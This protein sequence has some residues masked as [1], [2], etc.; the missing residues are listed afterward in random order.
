MPGVSW[1]TSGVPVGVSRRSTCVVSA[2]AAGTQGVQSTCGVRDGVW[3]TLASHK[4]LVAGQHWC[5][6]GRSVTLVA[7]HSLPHEAPACP[8]RLAGRWCHPL[9]GFTHAIELLDTIPGVDQRGA[10]V[11]VAEIGIDMARFETAP[12]LAAWAGVAPGNDESA[13]KQRSGKTRK[14]NRSLRAVLTQ[15]AHAAVR[16]KGTNLSA[17]YR[18]LAARRG[19]QRAIIAVAHSIM[20]S[21]F[22]MLSRNEP[23]R[24][25]GANYFDERRRHYT[26]DR[27]A[28]R[29]E[30]LGYHVSLELATTLAA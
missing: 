28:R 9:R 25:L 20:R 29:I 12:R 2:G 3:K 27:L 8:W 14:G 4:R 13:G 7:C 6:F 18:H 17:L 23:Y 22:H 30:H 26:V 1:V 16:T 5:G 19:Q 10:E 24:E 21:V 15:L 11:I